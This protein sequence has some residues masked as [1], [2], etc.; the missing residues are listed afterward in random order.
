MA[1]YLHLGVCQAFQTKIKLLVCSSKPEPPSLIL[2]PFCK[3]LCW[4]PGEETKF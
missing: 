3:E 1:L 2:P 4:H